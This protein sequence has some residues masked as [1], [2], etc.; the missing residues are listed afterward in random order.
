M[1]YIDNKL[2]CCLPFTHLHE[3]LISWITYGPNTPTHYI[4]ATDMHPAIYIT[5]RYSLVLYD[6]IK[7][8]KTYISDRQTKTL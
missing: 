8:L 4:D 1:Y 7:K 2:M 6:K 5:G 3:Y